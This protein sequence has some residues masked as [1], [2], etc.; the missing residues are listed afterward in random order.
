[1]LPFGSEPQRQ[2]MVHSGFSTASIFPQGQIDTLQLSTGT[3]NPG[4]PR[5]EPPPL[6][7]LSELGCQAEGLGALVSTTAAPTEAVMGLPFVK[8]P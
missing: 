6:P 5:P 7:P 4:R 2:V 3:S 8:R 1:M